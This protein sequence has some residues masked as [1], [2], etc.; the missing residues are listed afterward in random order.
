MRDLRRLSKY[1]GVTLTGFLSR[2][3]LPIF[4][5]IA[6][7]FTAWLIF[8]TTHRSDDEISILDYEDY[9]NSQHLLQF[10]LAKS[11]I[12]REV[13]AAL[14]IG[15]DHGV[16]WQG[17]QSRFDPRLL[18]ALWLHYL[19]HS[20]VSNKGQLEDSFSLRFSWRSFLGI[21]QLVS[22]DAALQSLSLVDVFEGLP[23]SL[24][25]LVS[26]S[27]ALRDKLTPLWNAATVKLAPDIALPQHLRRWAGLNYL[28]HSAP[29]P[30]KIAFLLPES[31]TFY[32]P[33]DQDV[34]QLSLQDK[35]E[36]ER[37]V[38]GYVS[39]AEDG[40][41]SSILL[42]QQTARLQYAFRNAPQ[43]SFWKSELPTFHG[44]DKIPFTKEEFEFD[45]QA[46]LEKRDKDAQDI[47]MAATIEA[48]LQK[49]PNFSKYFHEAACIGSYHGDHY[50]WR[51]F[52][53][54]TYSDYEKRTVLHLL[55]GAWLRFANNSGLKT[56]LAHGTLL[57]WYWNGLALPWDADVD[58][59]VSMSTLVRLARDFNQ[60]L[61]I[62]TSST[63]LD[64]G[65]RS[66]FIDVA[67]S[68]FSRKM[69]NGMNA[70]DARF[71]DTTTGFYIDITAVAF[72]HDSQSYSFN[73]T[74]RDTELIRML[75]LEE[76]DLAQ[77]YSQDKENIFKILTDARE[78]YIQNR[79]IFNCRNDHF[80]AF[81]ELH[82]LTKTTFEGVEAFVPLGYR[83]ILKRE[84][85][86]GLT[87]KFHENH[88]FRPYLDLWVPHSVCKKDR[89]GNQCFDRP[90]LLE[91]KHT[92]QVTEAH[93]LQDVPSG[94]IQIKDPSRYEKLTQELKFSTFRMDPWILRQSLRVRSLISME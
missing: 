51:F 5:F 49:A 17:L 44:D 30:K 76:Q 84:Y 91:T 1:L 42:A 56:W 65:I 81:E 21:S 9:R 50:D 27:S 63:D 59:Q 3:L 20:I 82:P 78:E 37:L 79:T 13:L 67:P 29:L 18:P 88:L 12:P 14:S 83:K 38:H 68:F 41:F 80:Y 16:V 43:S 28:Y 66:Y 54:L 31:P 26:T 87:S 47:E 11:Y 48:G 4:V 32:V 64:Q 62:D 86:K 53:R 73:G 45:P 19:A 23:R 89:Y 70:I 61:V 77:T 7:V 10:H 2:I 25:Q 22:E 24:I 92:R 57:G 34:S 74:K 60:T 72:T 93:N 52:K 71:I 90:T 75:D 6:G 94:K 69:G 85:P 35:L 36:L 8:H 15:V 58:V 40:D 39:Y 46:Y 33:V 55:V